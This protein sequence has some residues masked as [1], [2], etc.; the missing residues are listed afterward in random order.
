MRA[1]T[2][3]PGRRDLSRSR[4]GGRGRDRRRARPPRHAA[5]PPVSARHA[6]R[7]RRDAASCSSATASWREVRRDARGGARPRRAC[8]SGSTA[9]ADRTAAEALRGTRL[10]VRR[11][12]L[13]RAGRRR[14]LPSRR[15]SASPSRRSTAPCSARS[16]ASWRP[17]STTS[18]WCATGTREHLIPVIADVVRTIDRAGPARPHRPAPRAAGLTLRAHVITLFPELFGG[19]LA[20]GPLKR[21]RELGVLEV[22]LHQLRDYATRPPPPGRRR[23]VRRRPGMV[24]KPEPLV[25][26]IEHVVGG[27]ATAPRPARRSRRALRSAARRRAGGG[28]EPAP[29]LRALRGRRRARAR[30]RRRGA[31]DRRLRAQRRRARRPGRARRGRPPAPR[32]R[33]ATRRRPPDDSFA[34]GLLEYPQYTRPWSSAAPTS[35]TSS[36]PAITPPSRA[37]GGSSRCARRSPADP[38]CSH[39]RRSTTPT[40]RFLRALGWSAARA[41]GRWLI[42]TSP[43]CTTRSTTRTGAVVTTAVTNIDVHDIA[44]LART[45]GVRAFYVCTPVA[46]LRRLVARIIRHWDVGPGATYNA[47]RKEALA[48]V[49]QAPELDAAIADDRA[50][51]RAAA[52]AGR[53]VGPRRHRRV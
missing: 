27:G 47:T 3:I 23:A 13:P 50:R 24:M 51:D 39:A 36:S 5:R 16:R 46:T 45:F 38:T 30:V 21:A 41:P 53:D 1:G 25:A 48:L 6:E 44:R 11:A 52:A 42:S 31:V 2:G 22:S 18:G 35:P 15:R 40:A 20:V 33:S 8:S 10:L 19:P 14:V 29:R 32:R 37:G 4:R 49:R 34:T 17:A 9:C 7:W 26:A 12:D 43:S 28:A